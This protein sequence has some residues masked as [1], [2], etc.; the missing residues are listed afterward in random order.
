MS[1]LLESED[2]G[3]KERVESF[4][5]AAMQLILLQ[6][7]E[8]RPCHKLPSVVF[9]YSRNK[10]KDYI[11][12][13][14]KHRVRTDSEVRVAANSV[15]KTHESGLALL[16]Y[17]WLGLTLKTASKHVTGPRVVKKVTLKSDGI[18]V[19][20][21]DNGF[22][23][24]E[25][26]LLEND[27][28][29]NGKLLVKQAFE[30]Q[31]DFYMKNSG[32]A[33]CNLCND[34]CDKYLKYFPEPVK[35]VP[36]LVALSK[37]EPKPELGST[38]LSN[39]DYVKLILSDKDLSDKDLSLLKTKSER[40]C[41]SFAM[42]LKYN[43]GVI[44]SYPQY[45]SIVR[46]L[47]AINIGKML[48]QYLKTTGNLDTA[49][50]C[51]IAPDDILSWFR[52]EGSRRDKLRS[53]KPRS[54]KE[55]HLVVDPKFAIPELEVP[56]MSKVNMSAD[57]SLVIDDIVMMSVSSSTPSLSDKFVNLSSVLPKLVELD[58]MAHKLISEGQVI[59]DAVD[60]FRKRLL[61]SASM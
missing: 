49:G 51:N 41:V 11:N 3:F 21:F 17:S 15:F 22:P 26:D 10:I 60:N 40:A 37:P 39:T 38:L 33:A 52:V 16:L 18:V 4:V 56:V 53:R 20:E 45:L 43:N 25:L 23:T 29:L 55:S 8:F 47:D 28:V 12:Y 7:S 42:I 13:T 6:D 31:I 14:K 48:L 2:F 35:S 30:R 34:V 32:Q 36:E 19:I 27:N 59:R 1:S 54:V 5:P 57:T 9:E 50:K 24:R 46:K 61:Q 58:E 44:P